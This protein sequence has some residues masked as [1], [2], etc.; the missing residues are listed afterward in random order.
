[1]QTTTVQGPTPVPSVEAYADNPTCCINVHTSQVG[2]AGWL[3]YV[4]IGTL[5]VNGRDVNCRS[6]EQA[7]AIN[8][9]HHF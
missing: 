5:A 1:M 8:Q 6:R 7:S 2:T 4:V 3:R 9:V